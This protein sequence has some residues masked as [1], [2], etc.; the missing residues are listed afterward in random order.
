MTGQKT[1]EEFEVERWANPDEVYK[2]V[3]TECGTAARFESPGG[4]S[5]GETFEQICYNCSSGRFL[6]LG[7]RHKFRVVDSDPDPYAKSI[8]SGQVPVFQPNDSD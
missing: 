3:C 2:A 8:K 6:D 5:F 1:V 7:D 4:R